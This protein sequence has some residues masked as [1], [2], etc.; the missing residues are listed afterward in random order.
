MTCEIK[1]IISRT[2]VCFT[3]CEFILLIIAQAFINTDGKSDTLVSFLGLKPAFL[4]LVSSLVFNLLSYILKIKILPGAIKRILHY[5]LSMLCVA[6][7]CI[8]IPQ[9][10]EARFVL[11]LIFL[12]TLL[13]LLIW[14]V[15]F[16]LGRIFKGKTKGDGDY[17]SVFD[18]RRD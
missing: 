10:A 3:V 11:V 17:T 4:I 1:K 12:A 14:L 2:C 15:S 8:I 5:L 13:Y 16:L 18:E 6:I 9:R 7:I